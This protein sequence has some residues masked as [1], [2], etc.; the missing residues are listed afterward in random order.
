VPAVW[1]AIGVIILIGIGI[2][3]STNR[4]EPRDG[5]GPRY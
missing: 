5:A 4:H 1:I 3:G 2:M